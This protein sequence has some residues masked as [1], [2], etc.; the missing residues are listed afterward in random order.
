MEETIKNVAVCAIGASAG[1]VGALKELFRQLPN[2][3][4]LAYVVITHLSPDQPSA[5]HQILAGVTDLPTT[6]V[7]DRATLEPDHVYIIPPDRELVID[8]DDVR[9]RP[10][11]EARGHRAPVDM[12]FRSV[13]KGRGDGLAVILSGSGSD[14]AVG[15]RDIK[16]AGGVIFVQEPKTAEFPMMPRSAIAMGVADFVAPL[17]RLAERIVEVTK[18]KEAVR[19]LAVM[20]AD[21]LLQR[22]VSFLKSRTGHDFS[23]YKRA[24]VM[25][26]VARRMQVARCSDLSQYFEYVVTNP[27][28]AQELLGDLLISVTSFFRDASAYEALGKTV[29]GSLLENAGDA[30]IRIWVPGCATGEEAY[31]IA[32]LLLEEAAR[33]QVSIPIQIFAT[34]LDEGALATGREGRYPASIEAD[35][36]LERLQRFFVREGAHYRVRKELRD[37][38]LFA[39][40]SVLKDPPFMRLD[41]ISCRNLLIYL[42]RDLQRQVCALFAYGLRPHG[43]LYLGSAETADASAELFAPLDRE[44]RIYQAR[45][46][47]S[48]RLPVISQFPAEHKPG[49]L[50]SAQPQKSQGPDGAVSLVHHEALEHSAPPS[51]LVDRD[52]QLLN[53]SEN[54]G[55]FLLHSV[56]PPTTDITVLVRPELRLDVRTAVRQALDSGMT[57]LTPPMAVAFNGSRHRVSLYVAPGSA[58]RE[59]SVGQALILFLDAGPV[60][61]SAES[62]AENGEA[63]KLR[64]DL[65]AAH[66]RL[67]ASRAEHEGT[68]QDLRVANEE[69]Q[70]INEE[71][72]STAEELETSKEELQSMNEE[73][74]TVNAE[75]K[76]KLEAIGSAHSDLENLIAA[77]DIGTLF[78]DAKLRIRMFTPR[79]SEVFNITEA[80]VGRNL[81][82]FT[83][84]LTYD[85]VAEDAALVLRD[86]APVERE[87]Q[88]RDGRW[89]MLRIRPYRTVNDRIDGIVV[90]FVDVTER[91]EAHMRLRESEERQSFL[92]TLSDAL[93]PLSDAAEIQGEA[94][95]LL[96]KWLN[97]DRAYYVEVDEA[98]GVARVERDHVRDGGTSLAGEHGIAD[99]GWSV[100]ILRRGECHVIPDTQTSPLVPDADRP[101]SAALGIIGCMGAPLIKQRELVGALC[102]TTARR[103]DWTRH[104]RDL[105]SDVADRIWAAIERAR[106]E[107]AERHSEERYRLLFDMMTQGFCI[108]EMIFDE[109]GR[110]FDYR[111]LETNRAF[112]RQ[113]GLED[114][115]GRTMRSL[116]PG[117]EEIWF[118]TYARVARTRQPEHFESAAAALGRYYEVFAFPFGPPDASQVGI[119][120]NDVAGRK[121]TENALRESEQLFQQFGD[122]S[123]DALWIRDAKTLQFEYLSAAFEDVYGVA[124]GEASAEGGV[125]FF[126][127]LVI[128]EDR[129]R[130]LNE[131]K[132]LREDAAVIEFRIRRPR[133]GETRWIRS[134]GFNLIDADGSVRRLGG[135]CH[136]M[137]DERRTADR[138]QVLVG[139]LQHRT[140]NL[141]GVVKSIAQRTFR[142][143]TSLEQFSEDFFNRL[144]A[145]ARVN[146]LLSRLEDGSRVTFDQLIDAEMSGHGVTM[147][148][149]EGA[150]VMVDG[151]K[152][153]AL[154]SA[155]V[156]TLALA[157][158]ELLTNATKYGGLS[159]PE[160]RLTVFRRLVENGV[161]RLQIEWREVG[162]LATDAIDA[163]NGGGYGRELIERALPYQLGADTTYALDTE[164]L[165]CT[166]SL[167]LLERKKP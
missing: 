66:A 62:D 112:E 25:R 106:A 102:V 41:L 3:L 47:A 160:G 15:V 130:A 17:P 34:D 20:P 43:Y 149:G 57:T 53:V 76:S 131:F 48:R 7:T 33:R 110:A 94:C 125:E 12:F 22:I 74:Q 75:L 35:V 5:L 19:S 49:P 60:D 42:E 103:R 55:R 70:S 18:S 101:A 118:D 45:P 134:T 85:G 92:L 108:V 124:R 155:S 51:V 162:L 30:G 90:T 44:A 115:A 164:A 156:Q 4:G 105:L 39:S 58:P 16:E 95:R 165:R 153:V 143:S 11:T 114:A 91:R 151:P 126:R 166:I 135:I 117:H 6:Q 10:F 144:D 109:T 98:E 23:A 77:T 113:T 163:P 63:K 40:H 29:I 65:N 93:R 119:L 80:D 32:I 28:E 154:P 21:Q 167:P 116:R 86:L 68:I 56:G 78:L 37:V 82:D 127:D 159:N 128:A 52:Y 139:E 13:A 129:D 140:R 50:K 145:L 69:L 8:G 26:R 136:D 147:E 54:A 97:V 79:L 72:R 88:S 46:Q 148:T 121:R 152:G 123:S 104:E 137:T 31:S 99:F 120:F 96:A 122:A 138:M 64:E 71:Y 141:I 59:G 14:G 107:T 81:T 27:E 161:T 61:E 132:S 24:T 1:G 73:L 38:V 2:D 87:I 150:Q 67:S 157:I 133:D 83:H 146:S 89:L 36:S 111:F 158:H 9:A 84:H 100:E 142:A